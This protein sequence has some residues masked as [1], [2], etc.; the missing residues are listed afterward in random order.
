M[1][2]E[3]PPYTSDGTVQD[4]EREYFSNSELSIFFSITFRFFLKILY[5][6]LLKVCDA[7]FPMYLHLLSSV[8]SYHY[9]MNVYF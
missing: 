7:I 9:L 2:E 3:T 1:Q 4:V 8:G 5:D 6:P